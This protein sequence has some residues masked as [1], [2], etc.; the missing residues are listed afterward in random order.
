MLT[1]VIRVPRD[2]LRLLVALLLAVVALW[3][4][5]AAAQTTGTLQGT[6]YDP[7]EIEVPNSTVTLSSPQMIGG[8]QERVTDMTGRFRFVELL[9]G[10]YTLT[11]VAPGFQQTTVQ[12]I[13]VIAGRTLTQ[14]ISLVFGDEAIELVVEDVQPAVDTESTTVGTVLDKEFLQRIPAGRSYQQA[15]QLS[16]GV[17]G[18]SNPNAAG[19]ASNENTYLLD[20]AT[21]TD[22]VT[23]TFGN[24]FNFDAI[25][26]IEVLLGGYDP[27]YGVSLGGV[28]N[29]VTD[30]GT[31][32]LE[33]DTSVYYQNGDWRP[34]K[35]ARYTADGFELAPTGFDNTFTGLNVNARVSGPLVRDKA[36]FIFAYQH[37]RTLIANTG[38]PQRRDFD[39]HNLLSKLTIQPNSSHRITLLFQTDPASIDNTDQSNPFQKPEA[40]ARQSQA[41]FVAQ[42]RWQWF[43]NTSMN[44]DT[45][46]AV[47]KI[48]LENYS[49]PCTHNRDSD[50]HPCR[51]GE[52]EGEQD[53]FTPGRVG[54]F[55]A[56][57]SVNS[58]L[59]SFDDRW[60]FTAST[61]FSLLAVEDPLGGLHDFK[62]G[63]EGR[64]FLNNRVLGYTGNTYYVDANRA[65]FDPET[66]INYYWI[67]T[68]GPVR[69]RNTGSTW[70]FFLQ[71][72]YKPVSNVT[73]RYGMRFD[74]TVLRNDIGEPV[75]RGNLVGPRF[76][77]SWDPFKDQKT[78]IAGGWGRFN[79]AGRQA[80]A[81]FTSVA[82][83]GLKLYL[84]E[85]FAGQ[86]IDGL[87]VVNS[88][89]LMADFAPQE[90]P[91]IA[92]D[93]L[94]LPSL[95]EFIFLA[96]RQIAPNVR[97]AANF[98]A[99]LTRHLYEA[100]ELNLIYDEDGSAVIGSRRSDPFTNYFRLR[101]PREAQRN[102]YRLDT[103][104]SKVR[105]R[106]WGGSLTY[107]YTFINGTN[108]GSLAGAFTNDPQTQFIYGRLLTASEH[109]LRG[110]AFWDIP[111][112]P[113]TT[114]LGASIQYDSGIP[115]ERLYYSEAG[116]YSLR[117]RPRGLYFNFPSVWE[118]GFRIIQSIDVRKGQLQL[119]LQAQNVFN[120]RAASSLSGTFYTQNRLFALSR[121][122][123][124]TLQAGLRYQF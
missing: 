113:N 47:Q 48:S 86:G 3:G 13:Q 14:N 16:A 100:D 42:A 88:Q 116:G 124:F 5:P 39:G 55:G 59:Y 78:K 107:S 119:D 9:P 68:T 74:S 106:R 82:N 31:N 4:A 71:D 93:N 73:I 58:P 53:L 121:Q 77:A 117:I 76:Y 64:Q 94:R 30:S 75:V 24:N 38:I 28:F 40:Q 70:N 22:P 27:E 102:Y 26:Q 25:Q 89:E 43:L 80:V 108:N 34:R 61:K 92:N 123:P 35:D 50:R 98:Q 104:L 63:V 1:H 91:N 15:V 72:A 122:N 57:D 99:R 96:E 18:G 65:A 54:S 41:G 81:G 112:D 87:G 83:F 101:T 12:G 29:I 19:A 110:F 103:I 32:N 85:F 7:D 49:V 37:N 23:G 115:L 20:G 56:Y 6:V 45:R 105:A 44:L 52:I 67:E 118:V 109:S 8:K 21:V 84:G 46:L 2:G 62:F 11:V 17:T 95:D 114:T 10:E 97:L 69:Y 33:F 51:P 66:F 111:N 90:N 60:S 79:D 120:N 36:W